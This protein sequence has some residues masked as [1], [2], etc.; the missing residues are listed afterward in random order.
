MSEHKERSIKVG[1]EF[2]EELEKERQELLKQKS[3]LEE[4]TKVAYLKVHYA[5]TALMGNE[6]DKDL[7]DFINKSYVEPVRAEHRSAKRSEDEKIEGFERRIYAIDKVIESV[8]ISIDKAK[9]A[10]Y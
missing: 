3:E 4:E 7:Y 1:T 9:R 5:E 2:L 10:I 8:K 6:D